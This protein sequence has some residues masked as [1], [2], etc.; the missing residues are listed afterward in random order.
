MKKIILTLMLAVVFVCNANAQGNLAKQPAW[1]PEGYEVANYYY[2]PDLN[3]YYDVASALFYYLSGSSWVSSKYLPEKYKSYD[4]Y[5]LYKVV[6]NNESNPWNNN[7]THKTTY[8]DY[9]KDK[10]QTSI[11]YTSDE[12]YN[13]SKK[14]TESWVN[15][16]RA[17]NT[18]TTT[19]TTTTTKTTTTTTTAGGK[20]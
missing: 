17:N 6:I 15:P 11:R 19:T 2:M 4:L 5:S 12:K 8:K 20:R 18:K 1:G 13:E 14:N 9:K 3:I 10:T 16:D 7:K